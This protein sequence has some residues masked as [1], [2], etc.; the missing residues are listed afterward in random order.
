VERFYTFILPERWMS[1]FRAHVLGV[2]CEADNAISSLLQAL[3]EQL[4]HG[5]SEGAQAAAT[6]SGML[7]A[8]HGSG[9]HTTDPAMARGGR[10]GGGGGA[11][12]GAGGGGA[13][14][15]ERS[16]SASSASSPL[17][18]S[19][20]QPMLDD[21]LLHRRLVGAR[22]PVDMANMKVY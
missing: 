9:S 21:K 2:S 22:G 5:G 1:H 6:L 4:Q 17:L 16:S 18:T 13:A 14:R 11:G 10:G 7:A 8:Q 3:P 12:G 20:A 19:P 15:R